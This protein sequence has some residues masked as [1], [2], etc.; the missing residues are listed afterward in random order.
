MRGLSPQ[1]QAGASPEAYGSSADMA[2]AWVLNNISSAI[3]KQNMQIYL[4]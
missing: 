2:A 3:E 1:P 4:Q